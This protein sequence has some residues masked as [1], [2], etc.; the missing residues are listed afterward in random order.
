M[1]FLKKKTNFKDILFQT[2]KELLMQLKKSKKTIENVLDDK[3]KRKYL[4]YEYI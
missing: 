4:N 2:K 3:Y 1:R